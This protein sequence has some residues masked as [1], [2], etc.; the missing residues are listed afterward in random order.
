MVGL[1]G[2]NLAGHGPQ[3]GVPSHVSI[4]SDASH[5]TTIVATSRYIGNIRRSP[6]EINARRVIC[7]K[8]ARG[9]LGSRDYSHHQE[10]ATKALP[11][12][13]ASAK[14]VHAKNSEG[15]AS[16]KNANPQSKNAGNLAKIKNFKRHMDA[17]DL[18]DPFVIPKLI[19]PNALSVE[20]LWA[21]RKTTGVHLLKNWGK[22]SLHQC[23]AWQRDSFD[24]ASIEDLTS[25][26]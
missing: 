2:W 3:G 11:H 24:Y 13:F 21:E 25:M 12:I 18:L 15:E 22:A 7:P 17:W 9:V 14:H 19:N 16:N 20:D 5:A 10:V 1:A 8:N 4:A 23:K 26:E 6:A